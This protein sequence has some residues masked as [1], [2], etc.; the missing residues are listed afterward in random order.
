MSKCIVF[1]FLELFKRIINNNILWGFL[2]YE[3]IY[4]NNSV[5]VEKR[6]MAVYP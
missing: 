3:N 6:E 4:E 2:I 5:E 1:S